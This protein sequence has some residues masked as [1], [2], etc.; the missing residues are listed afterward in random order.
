MSSQTVHAPTSASD[1]P[2][3]RAGAV[4]L[5]LA[6][7]LLGAALGLGFYTFVYARGFSYLRDDASACMNCHVMQEQY[8]GWSRGSHR[9]VAVCNDCHTPPGLIAK[10]A[11]KASNG[12]RHSLAF[13]LGRFETNIQ[14]TPRN[15]DVTERACRHCHGA[16]VDAIE[17]GTTQTETLSCLACHRSAGHLH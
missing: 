10:Y 7:G 1:G 14:I 15:Y 12:F 4:L 5:V 17:L 13:T 8:V 2:R 9:S 11:T 6:A 3:G 16:I